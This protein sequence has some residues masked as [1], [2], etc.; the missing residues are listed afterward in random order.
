MSA[1]VT[2]QLVERDVRL[3][4]DYLRSNLPAQ[5]QMASSYWT[6]QS[7]YPNVTVEPPNDY[8]IYPRAQAYRAPA[9]FIIPERQ[10]FK[11]RERQANFIDS[12]TRINISVVIEDK[13]SVSLTYKAY[14][15][16]AAMVGVL[17]QAVLT[18]ADN[19]V[20]I[21]V[22]VANAQFSPLYSSEKD[23][24]ASGAVFRKEVWLECDVQH[25]ESLS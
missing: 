6:S 5:L 10:D 24:Q 19:K 20:K 12:E 22:V 1:S 15:Y 8:F 18:S 21:T 25:Y 23:P 2:L 16:Q 3:L 9:V 11:K 17:D 4:A 7:S 13:D 14:R